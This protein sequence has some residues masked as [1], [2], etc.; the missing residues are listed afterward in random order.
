VADAAGVVRLPR[1][2]ERPERGQFCDDCSQATAQAQQLK[3]VAE[4]E[5]GRGDSIGARETLR[6]IAQT[7][8]VHLGD[9]DR[10]MRMLE[11]VS[12]T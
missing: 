10:L 3:I 11:R 9:R 6:T 4:I 7:Q 8:L 2:S 5:G 12:E 1:R